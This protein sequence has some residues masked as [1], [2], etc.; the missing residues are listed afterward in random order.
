MSCYNCKNAEIFVKPREYD[1][2]A[3]HGV[4]MKRMGKNGHY[5]ALPI[6][7][8]G[9]RCKDEIPTRSDSRQVQMDLMEDIQQV[10]M[11]LMEDIQDDPH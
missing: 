6:Y 9:A 10:Q 2:F 7:I 1:G 4:C 3:V 5:D 11:D 8:P